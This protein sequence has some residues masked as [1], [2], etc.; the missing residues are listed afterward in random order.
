MAFP[1]IPGMGGAGV[2]AGISDH[3][4]KTIQMVR[5]AFAGAHITR[6]AN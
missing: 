5:F 2:D 3:E 6:K 4:K 1:G